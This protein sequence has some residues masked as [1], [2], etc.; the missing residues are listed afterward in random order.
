MI[1]SPLHVLFIT[2]YFHP[3]V[4]APQTRLLDL[5]LGLSRRGH[6]ITILTGFPNYPD[7]VMDLPVYPTHDDDRQPER[8]PTTS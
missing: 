2:H 6:S 3:E 5:A 8:A 7:G 4:G 1:R